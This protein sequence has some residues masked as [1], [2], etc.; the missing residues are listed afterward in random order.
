MG[1]SEWL[2][3]SFWLVLA[4]ALALA[5]CGSFG[6]TPSPAPGPEQTTQPGLEGLGPLPEYRL[7]LALDPETGRLTGS[8]EVT[9]PNR[10]GIDL[11]EIVFRLYPNLPQYGGRLRVDS[12]TVDPWVQSCGY[13]RS[14]SSP[15]CPSVWQRLRPSLVFRRARSGT[16]TSPMRP[17][18]PIP[19]P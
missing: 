1:A 17:F 2:R 19:R 18:T 3:R 16:R 13:D 7:T 9:V 14:L 11:Y 15:Q 8:Q 4:G 5:A 10:S 6:P 12:I